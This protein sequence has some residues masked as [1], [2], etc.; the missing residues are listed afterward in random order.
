MNCLTKCCF[1]FDSDGTPEIP[2]IEVID[3]NGKPIQ[4]RPLERAKKTDSIFVK[5]VDKAVT[6]TF[7][8]ML[9]EKK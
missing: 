2:K 6:I 1:S 7:K 5:P 8:Q 3:S 9:K 4:N